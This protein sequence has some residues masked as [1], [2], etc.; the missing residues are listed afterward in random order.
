MTNKSGPKHKGFYILPNLLTTASL[1]IGFMGILWAIEGRFELTALAILAACIFDGLDGKIARL[2]NSTSDFGIQ[3]DSLSDLVSFGVCPALMIYL[4]QTHAFDQ[5]GLAVAFL[6]MACGALR[7]ARFNL[8]TKNLPKSFFLGLPIPAAACTLATLVL[9][10]TYLPE[11]LLT[12]VLPKATLALTFAL[13]LLM[14]SKVKY[15]SFK[16]LE[17]VRLHPFSSTV[18]AIMIFVLVASEPKFLGF[19]FFMAYVFSGL[20]YTYLYLPLRKPAN[21]REPKKELS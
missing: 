9:F 1:F 19:L 8:Q 10:T 11:T 2:T 4:W 16:E 15:A 5:V 3:F 17:M 13:G 7:L 14:I 18:T 21:L 6:F 12:V 20:I